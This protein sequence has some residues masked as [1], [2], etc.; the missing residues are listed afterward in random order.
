[1]KIILYGWIDHLNFKNEESIHSTEAIRAMHSTIA[2]LSLYIESWTI[3]LSIA[4]IAPCYGSFLRSQS[5]E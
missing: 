3:E 1:M 5:L 2:Q 4:R